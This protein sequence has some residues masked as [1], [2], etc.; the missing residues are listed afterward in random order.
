MLPTPDHVPE[1]QLL[2]TV[3]P[4]VAAKVPLVQGEHAVRLTT[5][6]PAVQ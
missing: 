6:A 3:T 1:A 5:Y 2:Q 4:A